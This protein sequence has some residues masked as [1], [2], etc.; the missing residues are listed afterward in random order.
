M[1]TAAADQAPT[2]ATGAGPGRPPRGP[3]SGFFR[4]PEAFRAL[5]ALVPP[6]F[7]GKG[8]DDAVRVW[9]AGCATGEEA[10]S[11]AILLREHAATLD[12]PPGVEMFAT[13]VDARG[14]AR[15]RNALYPASAVACLPAARLSRFFVWEGSGYRVAKT[16]RESVLFAGHDV[17]RDPPFARLDLVSCRNLLTGLPDEERTRVL[18]TFYDAIVPGGLLFLGA[19]E[20]PAGDG[21]WTPAAGAHPVYRRD[22]A[23]AG[24]SAA[25]DG[26]A[27]AHTATGSRT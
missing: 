25:P 26:N 7:A 14:C 16:L 21:R 20:S 12:G 19:G 11:I 13:D 27:P 2:R 15:G 8:A 23:P 5:G 10:F 18:A 3:V 1:N 24:P 9:V 6:L 17:L 22:D 4:D